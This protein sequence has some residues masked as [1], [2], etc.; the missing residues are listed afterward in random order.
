MNESGRPE[1]LRET[2]HVQERR[3]NPGVDTLLQERFSKEQSPSRNPLG[4]YIP[5]EGTFESFVGGA[6]I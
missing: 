3:G 6:G 5:D 1:N 4:S 2:D